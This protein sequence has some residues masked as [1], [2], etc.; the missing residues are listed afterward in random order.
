M[1]AIS[2]YAFIQLIMHLYWNV[3]KDP[4]LHQTG[5]IQLFR[6]NNRNIKNVEVRFP[7]IYNSI[8][9]WH[10]CKMFKIDNEG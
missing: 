8:S 10:I 9:L 5:T 1:L 2:S 4:I 6:K 3:R 7:S